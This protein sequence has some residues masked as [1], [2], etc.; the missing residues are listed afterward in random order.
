MLGQYRYYWW[1]RASRVI[2]ETNLAG[3]WNEIIDEFPF[4]SYLLGDL[5]PHILAMPF[6]LL[7]VA[8]ALNL[9]LGGW[10]GEINLGFYRLPIRPLGFFFG[11]LLLGGLAFLNTWDILTGFGLLVGAYVLARVFALGWSWNRL[12]D[13]FAFGI[14][15]G[16]LAI[17]LYLPFYAGFSSQ[18]GG[19]I[20]NL[21][22][23][24]RGAQLWVMFGPLLLPI[25]AYLVYLWRVEKRP[26]NGKAGLGLALGLAL[27]LWVFSW[28]LALLAQYKMP[29][30]V[31]SYLA[32]DGFRNAASYFSAATLRRL[33][34]IGS[35]LTILS[36]TGAALAFLSKMQADKENDDADLSMRAERKNTSL[37]AIFLILLASLLVLAPEFVYLRDQ[38]GDRM[39]TIFKFYYQAWLLWSLAAAFGVAT[40]LMNLRGT[41]NWVYRIALTV[42]LFMA[43]VYPVLGVLTKTEDLRIP[44][45]MKNLAL[46]STVGNPPPQQTAFSVW[47]LDGGAYFEPIY[48][49]DMAAAAWLRSAPQGV[50][51]EATKVDASYSDFGHISIY[52][53]LPTVLGWPMHEAQ[54]RGSYDPQG[55]RLND[56]RQLYESSNWDNAKAILQQ[57]NI[58]YVF[59]GTLERQTFRINEQKFQQHLSQVFKQGQVVIYA[60]P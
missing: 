21:E 17:L 25:F 50:I 22:F 28:L 34:N 7:A 19:I 10:K 53:G 58:R 37:F 16:V 51:V 42:V 12:K 18:A 35:L 26:S 41:W 20:P 33:V 15:L 38:F 59:I 6:G 48:P 31:A 1:W 2:T 13:F 30:F 14:P 43:L 46:S 49:D 55:S 27:L 56:I 36:T 44:A 45:F 9:F 29:D 60:I 32:D 54:W 8:L 4:F 5:H 47:T 3:K 24:T 11:A 23:S 52:S 39:N 40:L 57:Y